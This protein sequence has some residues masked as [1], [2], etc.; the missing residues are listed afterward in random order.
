MKLKALQ[1]FSL[2]GGTA[3]S[4]RYGHRTSLDIDLFCHEKFDHEPII[5]TLKIEFGEGYST[6]S[7]YA[8]WGIFCY[9]NDVKVDIVHNPHPLIDAL[10]IT[11]GI[12]MYSDK[13]IIAM[14]LNAIL[15]R[16]KK[17]DFWDLA[18]LL[19]HYSLE[20]MISFHEA[21]YPD[22]NLLITIP[23]AITWFGDADESEDPIS[24]NGQTWEGVKKI[25][26]QEVRDFLR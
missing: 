11:N 15:G 6:E 4:L 20:N 3:L 8:R 5:T 7:K 22:Q 21:K 2:V 26:Q 19:Q 12:R 16:G 17:K 14:K 9:L 13:D 10:E 25:I 18:E 24:L 1:P 23:Q